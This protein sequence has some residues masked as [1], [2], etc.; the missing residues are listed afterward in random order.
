MPVLSSMYVDVRLRTHTQNTYR[1][2]FH[3]YINTRK[4]ERTHAR[5][6]ASTKAHARMHIHTQSMPTLAQMQSEHARDPAFV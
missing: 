6:H 3:A 2:V 4:H 1:P 5:M